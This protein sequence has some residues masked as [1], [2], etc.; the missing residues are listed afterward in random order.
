MDEDGNGRARLP[1]KLM[2]LP[3]MRNTPQ[4]PFREVLAMTTGC[5]C[6]G[7]FLE[8]QPPEENFGESKAVL[9]WKLEHFSEESVICNGDT[10][11][12]WRRP[13]SIKRRRKLYSRA[14]VAMQMAPFRKF[15]NN[16]HAEASMGNDGKKLN[17]VAARCNAVTDCWSK[18]KLERMHFQLH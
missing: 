15:R 6:G 8:Q 7:Q 13:Q 16:K 5:W 9:C 18:C 11:I 3:L 12:H 10:L 1:K 17:I 2:A 14:S 4:F